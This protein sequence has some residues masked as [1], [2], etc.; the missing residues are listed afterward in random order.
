MGLFGDIFS[1]FGAASAE[2]ASNEAVLMIQQARKEAKLKAREFQAQGNEFFDI[3]KEILDFSKSLRPTIESLFEFVGNSA[4]SGLTAAEELTL[5][6]SQRLLNENLASTGNLR[7]GA[8]SIANARLASEVFAGADTRRLNQLTTLAGIQ[9]GFA[10]Q[11]FIPGQIGSNLSG[12]AANLFQTAAGLS[13][14]QGQAKII[15][16]QASERKFQAQGAAADSAA[17]I[18]ASLFTGGLGGGAG[19]LGGG[20]ASFFG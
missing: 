14:S 12:L 8:A 20:Q 4:Q 7:S 18:V 5:T 1:A 2:D 10:S 13:P 15:A 11:A 19:G 3:T 16:G 17:Q 9:E 6:D